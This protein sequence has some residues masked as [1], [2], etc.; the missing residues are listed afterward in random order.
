M[1]FTTADL[2]DAFAPLIRLADPLFRGYG[3]ISRFAGRIETLR[4]F[5][6]NTLVRQVLETPGGGRVLVVDGG[7]SLRCALVGGRLAA[8]AQANGWSGLLVNGC[9]RDGVEIR[10]IPIGLKALNTSPM[11]SG[12]NGEGVRGGAV[13]FAGTTFSPGHFLYADEDGIVVA[14]RDLTG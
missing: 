8:L 11:R 1:E 13:S 2:C 3:G 12:K 9:I 7:G 6:D 4:V 5:E 14:D 10:E